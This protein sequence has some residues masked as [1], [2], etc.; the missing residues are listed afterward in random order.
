MRHKGIAFAVIALTL[1]LTSLDAVHAASLKV[2]PLGLDLSPSMSAGAIAITNL[3]TK[4]V[5]LQVRVFAWTQGDSEDRLVPTRDVVVSP[6]AATLHAG[7][8]YTVRL[9][10][11]ATRPVTTEESYRLVIDELPAPVVPGASGRGVQM[12]LRSTVP[13]F[14]ARDGATPD[15]RWRVWHQDGR[16]KVEATNTGDR[17]LRLS[18]LAISTAAGRVSFGAG[19]AGYVLPGQSQTFEAALDPKMPIVPGPATLSGQGASDEIN[20]TVIIDGR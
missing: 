14:F 6:P 10:R 16:L 18:N 7:E 19:L 2:S 12:L 13:V 15:V 4:D 17:H 8:T 20:A 9:L 5:S 11:V 1:S 3:D